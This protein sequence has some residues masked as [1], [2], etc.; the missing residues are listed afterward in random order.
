MSASYLAVADRLRARIFAGELA[1]GARLPS[2]AQL[3]RDEHIGKTQAENVLSLLISEGLAEAR[4]GSGTYVRQ[5]APQIRI[6]RMHYGAPAGAGSPFAVEQ[7]AAGRV[8]S[9]SNQSD[10]TTVLPAIAG[11]LGIEPGDR[12]MRTA[13]VFTSNAQPVMLSTSYE[14]LAITGRTPIM[15]PEAGPYAAAGVVDRMAAIGITVAYAREEPWARRALAAEAELLGGVAGDLVIVI[16]R[17][18]LA[19]D[20]RPVETAD[21]VIPADRYRLVYEVPVGPQQ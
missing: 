16:E 21:I 14:P 10:A 9:W 20:G 11:R 18:Y 3:Q 1:P 8:P 4:I 12:V 5:R 2:I 6:A 7:R 19:T 15:L 13:Y 17:T